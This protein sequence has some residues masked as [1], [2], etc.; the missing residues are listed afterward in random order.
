MGDRRRGF[1]AKLRAE[2][3]GISPISIIESCASV[4]MALVKLTIHAAQVGAWLTVMKERKV[5]G[6][7]EGWVAENCPFSIDSAQRYMK[8]Y[9]KLIALPKTALVRFLDMPVNTAYRELSVVKTPMELEPVETPPLPEGVFDVI[10]IDPPWQIAKQRRTHASIGTA[11]YYLSFP[12][13][14]V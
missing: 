6:E 9:R 13:H 11:A 1:E 10:V 12:N 5:H 4:I 3:K 7:W 8:L 2:R 14:F